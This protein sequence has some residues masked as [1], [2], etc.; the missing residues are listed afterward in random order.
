MLSSIPAPRPR[1]RGR[2]DRLA[3]RQAMA[4][5]VRVRPLRR[6]DGELLVRVL[7]GMSDESRYQRF[8]G[9]KP[10]LTSADRT[11][12]SNVDGRDHIAL[13]ALAPDGAPL[14]VARAVR[15]QDDPSAAEVAIE[16][17]DAWQHRGLGGELTARLARSAAAVGM[18]RL[19]AHVLSSS[20]LSG[21]LRRR[22][23]RQ[24]ERDGR[25]VVLVAD[26]WVVA[27]FARSDAAV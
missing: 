19:V 1:D 27:R 3:G 6:D 16:V 26:A 4:L 10:R 12:L 20:G 25:S 18:E 17:V 13:I 14:A 2:S 7:A 23:W 24:L 9:P 11:Y 5:P 15:L 21:S 8:H 22:G